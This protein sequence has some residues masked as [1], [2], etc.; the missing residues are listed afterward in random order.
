MRRY[1]NIIIK[2]CLLFGQIHFSV[3]VSEWPRNWPGKCVNGAC[4]GGELSE[5]QLEERLETLVAKQAKVSE[6]INHYMDC[7]CSVLHSDDINC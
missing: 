6:R 1:K 5:F 4:R 3:K 7:L 2:K